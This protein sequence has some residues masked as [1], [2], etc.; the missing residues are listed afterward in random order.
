M[1][2]LLSPAKTLDFE[3]ASFNDLC[4]KPDFLEQASELVE[5]MKGYSVPD[6]RTLMGVSDKIAAL[7]VQRFQDWQQPF[8]MQNAKQA[9]FAFKGDVYTGLAVETMDE[10][11]LHYLQ[12]HLRILSG[13]YGLLRAMDLI[14]AYR[15]EMGTRLSTPKGSTLYAF[16]GK[17]LTEKLNTLF[18]DE[19]TAVLVNLASNEYFKAVQTDAIQARIVT[20]VFKDQ[21]KGVYKIVSFYAKKARGMMLRYA[22]DNKVSDVNMLKRFDYGGYRFSAEHS[23]DNEWVFLRDE[24]RDEPRGATK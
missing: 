16:W 15:L 23:G 8:T 6:V 1:I 17:K 14:Q 13:L 9:V 19:K 2:F 10:T 4:T 21:K 7:N 12:Q 24:L 20:P 18:Q 3:S 11:A 5:I 22:A